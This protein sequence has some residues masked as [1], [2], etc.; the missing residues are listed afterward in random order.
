MRSDRKCTSAIFDIWGNLLPFL[1][2][3]PLVMA[4]IATVPELDKVSVE[5]PQAKKGVQLAGFAAGIASVGHLVVIYA[6]VSLSLL[7][8]IAVGMDKGRQRSR[9]C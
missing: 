5:K 4:A 8:D 7:I 9:S 1:P 3:L 2:S 6:D